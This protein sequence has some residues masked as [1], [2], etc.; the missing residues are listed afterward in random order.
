M[1]PVSDLR[2]HSVLDLELEMLSPTQELRG[3]E[4]DIKFQPTKK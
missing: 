4:K 2:E 3:F 1:R